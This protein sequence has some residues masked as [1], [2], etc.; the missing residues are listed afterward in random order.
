MMIIKGFSPSKDVTRLEGY[1]Y[2]TRAIIEEKIVH[3]LEPQSTQEDQSLCV[4]SLY[5]MPSYCRQ[6][7][8]KAGSM[9]SDVSD[10]PCERGV[11]FSH[12]Q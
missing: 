4:A 12:L 1:L 11:Q 9:S 3:C 2:A 10:V 7:K 5:E 6:L 8:D